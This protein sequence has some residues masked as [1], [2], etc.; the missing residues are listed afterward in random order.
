[1]R[2]ERYA[3]EGIESGQRGTN[4]I[5]TERQEKCRERQQP[6]H[7][8]NDHMPAFPIKRERVVLAVRANDR[9]SGNAPRTII[10][11]NAWCMFHVTISA[12][13]TFRVVRAHAL[14]AMGTA[15]RDFRHDTILI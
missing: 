9:R 11:A 7:R 4:P 5:R 3:A 13:G 8:Q 6:H 2:A 12:S 15:N 10:T 1:A 14:A